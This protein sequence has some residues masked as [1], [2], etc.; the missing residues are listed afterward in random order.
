LFLF[1]FNSTILLQELARKSRMNWHM[2]F[3]DA[4]DANHHTIRVSQNKK[5]YYYSFEWGKEKGER[6]STGIFTYRRPIDDIQRR[7]NNEALAI[8][9]A[10]RAQM[11]LNQQSSN[12]GYFLQHK[13]QSNFFEY[14]ETFVK[15]NRKY[16]NRHLENSLRAFKTFIGKDTI[17]AQDITEKLCRKFQNYFL[18]KYHGETSSGYFMRFKRVLKKATKDGYFRHNPSQELPAK[19]GG[20]KKLK[21]ILNADEYS[22]LMKTPCLNHEVK[23]AF[24]FSL[25]TGLR[26]V[27]IKLL[28]WSMIKNNSV[29]V[30]QNKTKIPLEI[31]LHSIAKSTLGESK[32][33]LVFHLSTQD[34]ANK[35]LGKWCTDA[36]LDKHITWHCARHSFSVLLQQKGVDIATIA[37][38]LGHTSSKYIHDTY[39][40]YIKID[41]EKASQKL[42]F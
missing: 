12:S 10:K 13:L 22:K 34:G 20:N 9:E 28:S 7:H 35:I 21:E 41:A 25:Y 11:I 1:S 17:E 37:G 14:Y 8:L 15:S 39:K 26:W 36:K 4:S 30:I 27:D 2:T 33:G 24:V 18:E 40:R 31:P 16:G 32:E 42:P 19:V 23:K 3:S 29:S 6:I 5:L 38:I